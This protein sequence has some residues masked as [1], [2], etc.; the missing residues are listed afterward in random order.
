MKKVIFFVM[1]FIL[2]AQIVLAKVNKGI[3]AGNVTNQSGRGLSGLTVTA[4]S[5]NLHN[6]INLGMTTTD[7]NGSFRI[8]YSLGRKE[9]FLGEP[10]INLYVIVSNKQGEIMY[11]SQN[12]VRFQATQ[13]ENFNIKIKTKMRYNPKYNP[14]YNPR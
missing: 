5:K 10:S 8:N 3:V 6:D 4:Y 12:Q 1:V 2:S 13:K 9:D 7:R 14:S 11:S